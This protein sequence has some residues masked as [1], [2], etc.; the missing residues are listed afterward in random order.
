MK[1]QKMNDLATQADYLLLQM[2][3]DISGVH[4]KMACI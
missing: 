1:E 2:L 3:T 4:D